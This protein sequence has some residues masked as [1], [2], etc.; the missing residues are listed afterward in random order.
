VQAAISRIRD[1]PKVLFLLSVGNGGAPMSGGAA[2]SSDGVIRLAGGVN[3][4]A[5]FEGYR[6]VSPEAIIEAAPDIVL[7]TH[8]SLRMLGGVDALLARPAIAATPAGRAKRVVAMDGLLLLGFG[9]RI[10]EAIVTLARSLHPDAAVGLTE[11]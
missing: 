6:P 1:R 10:G 5:G 3:A 8:R 11:N 7:V 2:T 9:P 4:V